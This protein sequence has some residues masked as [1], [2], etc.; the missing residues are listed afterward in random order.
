LDAL[1]DEHKPVKPN[2]QTGQTAFGEFTSL[3]SQVEMS[4]TPEYWADPIISP[5]GS[6]KPEWLPQNEAASITSRELTKAS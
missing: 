2:L 1:G 5:I 6:S 4:E 3:G